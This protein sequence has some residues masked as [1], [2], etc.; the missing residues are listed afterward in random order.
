MARS[1][2]SAAA[3]SV[4]GNCKRPLI[5]PNKWVLK[6]RTSFEL[7]DA[8]S[9][10][11]WLVFA[12]VQ[13]QYNLLDRFSELETVYIIAMIICSIVAVTHRLVSSVPSR[14]PR[15]IVHLALV[16][17]E[18]SVKYYYYLRAIDSNRP[19]VQAAGWLVV[20]R[21]TKPPLTSLKVALLTLMS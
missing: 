7:F 5:C 14:T 18:R 6:V 1:A 19:H 12:S 11:P 21:K 20:T 17:S 13:Q 3:T 8:S 16:P 2:T 9:L 15:E 10:T 4:A